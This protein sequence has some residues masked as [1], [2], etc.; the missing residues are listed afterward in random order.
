MKKVDVNINDRLLGE[1]LIDKPS[2]R[3]LNEVE[4]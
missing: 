1:H 4:A 2:N 3:C